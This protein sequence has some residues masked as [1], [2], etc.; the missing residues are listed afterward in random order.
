[1]ANYTLLPTM[2]F[3]EID[4]G[5]SGKIANKMGDLIGDMGKKMQIFA[6]THL[7]QIASKKGT[8]YVVYKEFDENE[9]PKTK[10][11]KISEQERVEELARMLSGSILTEAAIENARVLLNN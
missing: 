11:R 3:A 10:I 2:I 6:I 8:H 5:V 4:V 9:N 1:M 7:P